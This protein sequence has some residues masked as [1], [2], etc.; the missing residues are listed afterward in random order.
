MAIQILIDGRPLPPERAI[1]EGLPSD[2]ALACPH[3]NGRHVEARM[4]RTVERFQGEFKEMVPRL[5]DRSCLD[6]G[7]RWQTTLPP[8]FQAAV[9]PYP[10]FSPFI[11][12]R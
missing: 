4:A 3:C 9:N 7:A 10:G 5:Q 8:A 1:R 11:V 2:T 6:C 12:I